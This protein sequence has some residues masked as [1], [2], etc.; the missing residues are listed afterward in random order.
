MSETTAAETA[1]RHSIAVLPG[2]GIGPEV[3]AEAVKVLDAVTE[4]AGITLERTE[5]PLGAEHWLATGEVLHDD[6]ME[7]LRGHHAILF[8]AVGAAPNDKR[9]P[10][11]ILERDLLLKL[12]F[13]FDH[14]INLRPATLYPGTTSPLAEPGDIDF[15]V[16]REG[17]E[18]LYAG[19][20]GTLRKGTVHEVASEVSQN[21]CLLYTSDAADD[22][23]WV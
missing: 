6:T 18:G 2:D 22:I 9:V 5:Y 12:R 11:G 1:R 23:L 21:T 10:S 7:R 17:T 19:N 15:V 4:P 13:G 16:V 3:V 8:G 14:Y 20:G